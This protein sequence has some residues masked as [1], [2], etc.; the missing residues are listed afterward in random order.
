VDIAEKRTYRFP[1]ARFS[2]SD[3]P[4]V[5]AIAVSG[6]DLSRQF[7]KLLEALP[8]ACSSAPGRRADKDGTDRWLD[9]L[10]HL[11]AASGDHAVWTARRIP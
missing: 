5:Y 2:G 1:A 3:W 7:N 10:D 6:R 4:T 11:I 8:D 9:N